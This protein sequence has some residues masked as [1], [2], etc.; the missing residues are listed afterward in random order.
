MDK[1][2]QALEQTHTWVLTPLPPGK[3][4]IGCKWVYRVKLNPDGTIERYKA[5]LVAKGY[6]QRERHDFS[7]TFSPVAKTVSVR[8]LIALASTKGWPLYQLDI[9]NAF[10]HGD[11]DEEVY[12]DL[13]LVF[14][15][16]GSLLTLLMLLLRYANW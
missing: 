10:L 8:V 7:E 16:R 1:E 12:M 15:A 13:P 2:I 14:T 11:L 4:P 9:N 5:R 3:R 6:T